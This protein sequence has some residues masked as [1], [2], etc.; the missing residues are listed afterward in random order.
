MN[1]LEITLLTTL[2]Y[3]SGFLSGLGFCF[4]YKKNLLLKTTSQTQLNELVTSLNDRNAVTNQG[5]PLAYAE[6]SYTQP[7]APKSSELNEVV[8]RTR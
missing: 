4:K 8:I 2:F 7:S 1:G 3:M 6:A 5:P